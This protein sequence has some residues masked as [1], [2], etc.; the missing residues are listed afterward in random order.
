MMQVTIR[1]HPLKNNMIQ[2]TNHHKKIYSY[3]HAITLQKL[4]KITA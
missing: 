4:I 3:Q 1:V 2:I